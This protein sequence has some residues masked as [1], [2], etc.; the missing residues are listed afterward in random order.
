[1]AFHG[2]LGNAEIFGDFGVGNL[3]VPQLERVVAAHARSFMPADAAS[4][5]AASQS[6]KLFGDAA[7][8]NLNYVV[9]ERDRPLQQAD[10]RYYDRLVAALRADTE[11][12]YSI[13]DLWADPI[14]ESAAQSRDGR[15]ADLM[16]RLSGM[17]GT[18]QASDAVAVVRDTAARLGP[19]SGL[20]VYTTGPG[21]T[22]TDEFAAIDH[23]MLL[24]TAA[25]VMVILVLLLIVYRS[26]V[27]AA[28]P[29]ISVGLAL[30]VARPLV[31]ALGNHRIV[32]VSLFSVALVAA[33]ILGAGTDYAIFLIGRYHEGRRRGTERAAALVDAYRGVAPV[34]IGSALTMAAALACL[35]LAKVGMFRSTGIPCAVGVLVGMLAALTLTPALIGLASRRGMLEPRR[36]VIARRWRR[37]GVAV[38]RW[39]GPVMVA[40][41][42]LI[43]VLILPLAGMRTGWNEPAAT[44]AGAESNRGYAAMDRHFPANR[45]LPDVVTVQADHDLRNPAG[46]IA[47]ERITRQVMASRGS[48]GAVGPPSGS[49][50]CWTP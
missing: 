21:G 46:L 12:V 31:A 38:A 3:A 28:I 33:M 11:H 23:Q 22:L 47:V 35:S 34:V 6:A 36:A 19:P 4:A 37:I 27:A 39:P 17:L 16:L 41:A 20:H 18:S 1:M 42:G 14:T 50:C 30:A 48:D 13:T 8:N 7:S 24:I 10:R 44:P 26:P 15:A 29:L 5:V 49:G 25:T 40:S 32:E 9:L 2:Q 45:R 43:A